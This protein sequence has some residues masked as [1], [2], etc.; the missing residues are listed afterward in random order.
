GLV[1]ILVAWWQKDTIKETESYARL[2]GN[3]VV[4]LNIIKRPGEN[5]I[6]CAT[7]V[8]EIVK[9]MKANDLP[10]DLEITITGDQSR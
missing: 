2:N 1:G 5:L 3:N 9:D 7:Q 8:K 10:K 4:T 6:D